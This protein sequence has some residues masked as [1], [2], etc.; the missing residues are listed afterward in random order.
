MIA[1]FLRFGVVGGCGFLV[2]TA[3]VYALRHPLGLYGA[4]AVSYVIAASFT[5]A[6]NRFWTFRDRPRGRAHRQWGLFMLTNLVGFALNRG[7]YALMI[8]T[9]PLCVHYPVLAVAG[10]AIA[11]MGVNYAMAHRI[12][13]R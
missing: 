3:V 10:G 13:F 4:G 2:D 7:A 8:A 5:W 1:R 6:L 9:L 12:V 11:G